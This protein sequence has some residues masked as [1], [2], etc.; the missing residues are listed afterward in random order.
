MIDNSLIFSDGNSSFELIAGLDK[1]GYTISDQVDFGKRTGGGY[2]H[3]YVRTLPLVAAGALIYY[4]GG[5]A[6]G[7]F[8]PVALN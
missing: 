3:R 1:I 7:A 4:T 6:A 8:V 2:Y 5:A